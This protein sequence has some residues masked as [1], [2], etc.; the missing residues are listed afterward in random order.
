MDINTIYTMYICCLANVSCALFS[1]QH[2]HSHLMMTRKMWRKLQWT[3]EFILSLFPSTC[4]S[5]QCG[6][7]GKKRKEWEG[8]RT[9]VGSTLQPNHPHLYQCILNVY[10]CVCENWRYIYIISERSK[11]FQWI[12]QYYTNPYIDSTI[13]KQPST[14]EHTQPSNNNKSKGKYV[15]TLC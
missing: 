2:L 1:I 4:R 8:C 14:N 10:V 11:Q 13:T 3:F 7:R 5:N 9:S 15:D 6:K 12:L